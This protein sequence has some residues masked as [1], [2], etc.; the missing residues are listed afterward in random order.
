MF[1]RGGK[2]GEKDVGATSEA[3]LEFRIVTEISETLT[4]ILTGDL[5]VKKEEHEIRRSTYRFHRNAFWR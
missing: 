1:W 4:Q 5:R 3:G 2:R